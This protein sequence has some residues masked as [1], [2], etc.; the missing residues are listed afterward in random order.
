MSPRYALHRR[1]GGPRAVLD[2]VVKRKTPN[3]RRKSNPRTPIIQP[4]ASAIPTELSR[5]LVIE[6]NSGKAEDSRKNFQENNTHKTDQQIW[7]IILQLQQKLNK[8]VYENEPLYS[9][10]EAI[11]FSRE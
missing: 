11:S 5:V 8:S 2:A 3:P 9:V 1:L 6:Y 4:V 7:I 10:K